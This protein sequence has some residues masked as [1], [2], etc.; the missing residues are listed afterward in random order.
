VDVRV[1]ATTNRDLA[2]Q[3]AS[4]VFR[5]DLY[6]RLAVLPIQVP[7][8]RDRAE[9]VP[10]LLDHFARQ[11]AARLSTAPVTFE[12][13]A[14]ELLV[15]HPWPGNVRELANIVTRASVLAPGGTV[16]ADSVRGWLLDVGGRSSK[17][18]AVTVGMSLHEMERALIEATLEKFGGHRA[19][20]A[21]VLGIG[22]RTLSGKL[23]EYGY[24]PR[25]KSFARAS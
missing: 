16:R 11:V 8:L 14:C 5:E 15:D 20:A 23:R 4:G 3:V 22:I 12:P 6:Y 21:Q 25:A 2:A 19:K 7:P 17:P 10:L 24:A 13:A 1:L 18:T 9:D